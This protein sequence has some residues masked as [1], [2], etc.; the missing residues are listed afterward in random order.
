M[1]VGYTL[2]WLVII[3]LILF[4]FCFAKFEISVVAHEIPLNKSQVHKLYILLF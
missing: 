4:T 3:I 1:N 2:E